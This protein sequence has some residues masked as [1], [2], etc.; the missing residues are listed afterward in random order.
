[1]HSDDREGARRAG[2]RGKRPRQSFNQARN[3]QVAGR[4]S[5]AAAHRDARTGRLPGTSV[6]FRAR[7]Q[8]WRTIGTCP[9][10]SCRGLRCE[11]HHVAFSVG[12]G[13]RRSRHPQSVSLAVGHH[14][15]ARVGIF[16]PDILPVGLA[17]R[18]ART[19]QYGCADLPWRAA[20]L[21]HEFLRNDG[22]WPARLFRCGYLPAVRSAG[23][24]HARPHGA[25]TRPACGKGVGAAFCTWRV[26]TAGGRYAALSPDKRDS[27]RDDHFAGGRRT[28]ACRCERH[29]GD[30]GNG[31]LAGVGRACA[32]PGRHRLCPA[33]GN[34]EI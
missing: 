33:G 26:R 2:R 15:A 34:A 12:L 9:R 1:M 27:D 20:G 16:R 17:G 32:R 24:T 14:R 23:G 31:R 29:Q 25:R 30:I 8:G 11:Q 4:Q 7:Q 10:A 6:R 19:H 13:G 3:H 5:S 22:A 28:C 18:E 21:R